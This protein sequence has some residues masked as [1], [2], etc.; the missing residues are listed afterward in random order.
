[1]T[2]EAV[3]GRLHG[4][5][6]AAVREA[7]IPSMGPMALV[8]SLRDF[9]QAGGLLPQRRPAEGVTRAGAPPPPRRPA[10]LT[11][12]HGGAPPGRR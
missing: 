3:A 4:P 8:R 1:M 2:C 11:L 12:P 6:D 9:D 7:V 5:L 10:A